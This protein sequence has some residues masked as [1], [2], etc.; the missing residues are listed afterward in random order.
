MW[1]LEDE[2]MFW[3]REVLSLPALS[4]LVASL[5]NK[6]YTPFRFTLRGTTSSCRHPRNDKVH[7][8][9]SPRQEYHGICQG[10][11]IGTGNALPQKVPATE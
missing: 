11:L 9:P 8:N 5:R 10:R 4:F 7:I 3:K 1:V 6:T 2:N